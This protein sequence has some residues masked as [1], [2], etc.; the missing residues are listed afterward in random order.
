MNNRVRHDQFSTSDQGMK[1]STKRLTLSHLSNSKGITEFI[2]INQHAVLGFR[3]SHGCKQNGYPLHEG[4][5]GNK[6]H[7][8]QNTKTTKIE[9]MKLFQRDWIEMDLFMI[10]RIN[11]NIINWQYINP[12]TEKIFSPA[13][14]NIARIF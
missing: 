3:R 1:K 12:K 9:L 5:V 11:A 7:Q 10:S 6:T 4:K 14:S 8:L 13:S 2:L